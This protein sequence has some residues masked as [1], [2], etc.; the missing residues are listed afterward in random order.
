[1]GV[2]GTLFFECVFV[3]RML[4]NGVDMF[5]VGREEGLHMRVR[6]M[7]FMFLFTNQPN[8]LFEHFNAIFH[9]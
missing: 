4:G 8:I 1:M 9:Y 3:F 5:F 2:K 7:C 6:L